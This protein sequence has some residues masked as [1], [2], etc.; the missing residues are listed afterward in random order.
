MDD[1]VYPVHESVSRVIV[2]EIARRDIRAAACVRG[3][4]CED[5]VVVRTQQRSDRP[6]EAARGRGQ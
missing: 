6:A 1:G 3:E 2:A 4:I 5:E